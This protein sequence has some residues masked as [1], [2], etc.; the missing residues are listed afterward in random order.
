MEDKLLKVKF[1]FDKVKDMRSELNMLFSHLDGRHCKLSEIYD[2]FIKN[3]N[4]IRSPDVKVLI[5]SLDSFYFQNSLL[6]REYNYLK[7]Y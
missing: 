4:M 5:F 1:V 3:T 2:D 6:R 7:D